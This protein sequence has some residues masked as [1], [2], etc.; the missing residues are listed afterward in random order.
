MTKSGGLENL[1]IKI[2]IVALA[3]IAAFGL[4][5]DVAAQAKKSTKK[6]VVRK[7]VV[8]KK[9]APRAP[10]AEVRLV[11]IALFADGIE[12]INRYGNPTDVE[13]VGGG[14]GGAVGPTGARG[15]AGG[16]GGGARSNPRGGAGGG[17]GA[18]ADALSIRP[19]TFNFGDEMLRLQG[20]PG[21]PSAAGAAAGGGGGQGPRRGGPDE[22]AGGP[23]AG[24]GGGVGSG[25]TGEKILYTRWIYNRGPSKYGFVLNKFNKVVQVEAIGMND[26]KVKT[27]RGIGYGATF[28]Q[29]IRKYGAPDGYEISGNSLVVRY[30]VKN[31]VAFRLNRLGE[32]KPHVVTGIVVAGGKM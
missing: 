17:G 12:V 22:G 24:P 20:P 6:P 30:L 4:S 21:A 18:A 11:G 7:K 3:C 25:N 5:A 27:A 1:K 26:A 8:A 29:I 13:A 9:P 15:P 2:G 28:S 16:G 19:G 23:A 14:G 10:S 32:N 31:K